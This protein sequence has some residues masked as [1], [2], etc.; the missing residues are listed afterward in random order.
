[1]G[2]DTDNGY[3]LQEVFKQCSENEDHFRSIKKDSSGMFS[4]ITQ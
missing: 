4:G 2:D 3:R 1:M